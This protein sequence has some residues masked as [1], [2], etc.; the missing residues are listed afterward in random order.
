MVGCPLFGASLIL[1]PELLKDITK[2]LG[3]TFLSMISY[4]TDSWIAVTTTNSFLAKFLTEEELIEASS[5]ALQKISIEM[6]ASPKSNP[7]SK[8]VFVYKRETNS[9]EIKANPFLEGEI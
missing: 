4:N 2:D 3:V 7:V 1:F 8:N 6:F 5:G 9:V